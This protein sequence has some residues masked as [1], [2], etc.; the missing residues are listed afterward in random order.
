MRWTPASISSSCRRPIA[1]WSSWRG[2]VRW[3]VRLTSTSGRVSCEREAPLHALRL[4]LRLLAETLG[5][6]QRGEAEREHEDEEAA[7]GGCRRDAHQNRK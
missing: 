1:T 5:V 6:E 7:R 4:D 3:S 2:L